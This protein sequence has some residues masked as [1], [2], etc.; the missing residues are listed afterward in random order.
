MAGNLPLIPQFLVLHPSHRRAMRSVLGF[1]ACLILLLFA[2]RFLIK[3]VTL[4]NAHYLP[5]HTL[6][7]TSS[8]VIAMMVFAVGWNAHRR[9]MPGHHLL[10]G[11]A[12]LGVGLLDF[13]HMLSYSGMPD[14]VTPSDPE[15]G[16]DFW[17]A[18]R[19]L[20]SVALLVVAVVHR[21]TF[22]SRS[23]RYVLLV[24]VLLITL[25]F[26]WVFL[27]HPD[28]TPRTFVP[29]QGLTLLKITTEYVIMAL[30]VVAALA[31]WH[32]MREPLPFN[33]A[34]LFAAVAIMSISELCFTLYASTTDTFNLLGHFFKSIAYFFLYR[35]IFV[36]TIEYPFAQLRSS[37]AQ[38]QATLDAIP[39]LLFEMDENGRYLAYHSASEEMLF[40]AP[41]MF[42]GRLCEEV[43]PP[44]AASVCL[45]AL[46]EAAT[47]GVSHGHQYMLE[48]NGGRHWFE[49]SVSRRSDLQE[50]ENRFIVLARN[51]TERMEANARL[52]KLSH[53]VEQN[54]NSIVITDLNARIE[55]ANPAFL[56]STGYTL[57]EVI[58]KNPRVLQTGKTP[59]HVYQEMWAQLNAGELWRG[60]FINRRKDGTEYI[61]MA[62]ISPVKKPDGT[63]VNYLAI[64][65]DVTEKKKA[66]ERIQKLAHFDP[67]TDL[68]NRV[69][70]GERVEHTLS[71]VQRAGIPMAVMFLD[72]DHFKVIN[73][74]LGH[75]IGDEVLVHVAG[76]F[77]S[78][79]RD[80]DTVARLGGDEFVFVFPGASAKQAT[81]VAQ[82]LLAAVTSTYVAGSH[83]LAITGS[84][85]I[86]MYPD[87]GIDFET[88]S[89]NADSAM[90]R[91]KKNGRNNFCFFAHE[92]QANSLRS[93]QL[94]NA[95]RQAL[96]REQLSLHF[97]PQITL[98]DGR[99]AGVEALLRWQ[100]PEWGMISPAEFI[101]IAE[102]NGIITAI[103]EWV[104]R[105]A[106]TQL[107][108][109]VDLG[110]AVNCVAVN[111]S[112]IQFR[113]A[114]FV[115]QVS[116]MLEEVDLPAHSL[117]LELT[118]GVA[119][120]DPEAAIAIMNELH[121]RGVKISIDD[122]GTGYSSLSYLKKFRISKIKID[123]S[124]VQDIT[125][126]QEDKA[127]V[128]AI[129]H[130][131]TSL[132]FRAIAEGV[133]TAEQLAFLREHGCHEVQ[134]YY[135]CRPL[136]PQ[137][138]EEFLKT[139]DQ[140]P[141]C[142]GGAGGC[143]HCP[144]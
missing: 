88:L 89:R 96:A 87:D 131:S 74:T 115:Q 137:D 13:S 100:H 93:L 60:E 38:I 107:K 37:E 50:E 58:G 42:L 23:S 26:H 44:H 72:L 55:Y 86:A 82:K 91:A 33:A 7:E 36:E 127:I 99:L 136:P 78:I 130:M 90:Y 53:A 108:Q 95:L 102:E 54:P 69:Y 28:L 129:I 8:V 94:S 112:A 6:L 10:L 140:A 14:Y 15:K 121:Q 123:K 47:H 39:D 119:M 56:Q 117:E 118:E 40:V 29:G 133:E 49:L 31:L 20:A 5:L 126:D 41:D 85:G 3:P 68:P 30:N 67:L 124:F 70:L 45:E 143:T 43:L 83:E 98:A 114:D 65:E 128:E 2:F 12:F 110:L 34:A 142:K 25:V 79:I 105:S 116:N 17:L 19:I 144:L 135:F 134:G 61:E 71:F 111:L 22:T 9:G 64:K 138:F 84:I 62:L 4:G 109:W 122:F 21:V 1:V 52:M 11:C 97:Q 75:S 113:N 81:Q 76:Q 32:R 35:G 101:P 73:D 66:E 51:V 92:M 125:T 77:K 46:R 104:L 57:D 132:G 141:L 27:F 24:V 63:I 18:A 139:L 120:H 80:E 16:I 106:L 103:G 48:L 59:A